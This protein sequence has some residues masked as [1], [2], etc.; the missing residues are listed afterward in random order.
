MSHIDI[1]NPDY[2]ARPNMFIIL[3]RMFQLQVKKD[4]INKITSRLLTHIPGKNRIDV[5]YLL[6]GKRHR[7]KPAALEEYLQ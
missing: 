4:R 6:E 2:K 5:T 3:Y 7:K 1:P